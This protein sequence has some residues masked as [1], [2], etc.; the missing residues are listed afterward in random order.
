MLCGEDEF[1]LNPKDLRSG[2]TERMLAVPG[3][4]LK[5]IGP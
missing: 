3:A 1:D 5:A 4:W 2:K